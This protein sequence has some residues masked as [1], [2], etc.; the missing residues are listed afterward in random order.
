MRSTPS[1]INSTDRMF[2][3]L[4]LKKLLYELRVSP[5]QL[6]TY[7]SRGFLWGSVHI[8]RA[9]TSATQSPAIEPW[10]CRCQDNSARLSPL[11][12]HLAVREGN[13]T[14]E[15]AHTWSE[16]SDS[17]DSTD[18]VY[19]GILVYWY[20]CDSHD[21]TAPGQSLVTVMTARTWSVSCHSHASS[22]WH[23]RVCVSVRS[24]HYLTCLSLTVISNFLAV[25]SNPRNK[26]VDKSY[27]TRPWLCNTSVTLRLVTP[28]KK[29][30][31]FLSLPSYKFFI[32]VAS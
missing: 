30:H 2:L 17:H 12:H 15:T 25:S 4:A 20:T 9:G 32:H 16:S 5:P 21:S 29:F 7:L 1:D 31:V 11:L 13:L 8:T 27:F 24:C 23:C 28:A 10:R 18:L 26:D 3:W 22:H 19:W 14:P 6:S